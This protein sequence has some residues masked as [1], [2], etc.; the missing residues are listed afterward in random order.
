VLRPAIV[1][2]RPFAHCRMLVAAMLA[3]RV[4]LLH[5]A[6]LVQQARQRLMAM[7]V[8]AGALAL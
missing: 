5:P 4:G 7:L 8:A 2:C 1:R 6:T 3:L